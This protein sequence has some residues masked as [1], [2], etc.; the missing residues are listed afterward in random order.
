MQGDTGPV[1]AAESAAEALRTVNHLTMGAPS[2]GAPG[3]EDV[4]DLYRLLGEIKILMDRLPQVLGQLGQHLERPAGR[5]P[6]KTDAATTE[7]PEC[8]AAAAILA[9]D[10]ARRHVGEAGSY[11]DEA[12]NAVA[13]LYA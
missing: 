9:L 4:G 1:A 13:H 10:G 8:L 5:C 7:T 3:W 6:C 12:H 2:S 11:L